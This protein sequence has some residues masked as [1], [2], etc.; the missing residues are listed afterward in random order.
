MN[1]SLLE[2]PTLTGV[3]EDQ[4][5]FEDASLVLVSSDDSGKIYSLNKKEILIGNLPE[6]DICPSDPYLSRRHCI[7]Y[8]MSDGHYIRDLESKNGTYLN[9]ILIR[10]AKLFP[11]SLI[12]VGNTDLF[13][14]SG[15]EKG[16]FAPSKETWFGEVL[17]QSY[18]MRKL[19]S[20]LKQYAPSNLSLLIEGETGTGK[21]QL[22][23]SIHQNSARKE[24]PFITLD[25]AGMNGELFESQLFGYEKGA[26]T[27]AEESRMGV[28]ERANGG[29]LFLDEI[30]ELRPILQPKLLRALEQKEIRR[31]GG[32]QTISLDI[33]ILASST[34]NLENEVKSGNF[35][36]DLFYRLAVAR[37]QLPPLRERK[38]DISIIIESLLSSSNRIKGITPQAFQQL[39]EYDWPGNVRELKNILENAITL[40][41]NS[42]IQ[43]QDLMIPGGGFSME[44]NESLQPINLKRAGKTLEEMEKN[45]I[46]LV[47]KENNWNKAKSAKIL[48]IAESTIYEKIK[49][50][51]IKKITF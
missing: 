7:I 33:R 46:I 49:K 34:M 8:R 14:Q 22:A 42:L 23:R 18:P 39:Y 16:D 43:T 4:K 9:G 17:G 38:V 32:S 41:K 21:E 36:Q 44:E 27:G 19:F 29:T 30:G 15:I 6:S 13:Y 35:R 31:I 47:L 1:D 3:Q 45:A 37:I 2:K 48:G 51:K 26:F 24:H 25:C 11:G 40:S 50:Y 28:F 20:L 5:G 10:E 12:H